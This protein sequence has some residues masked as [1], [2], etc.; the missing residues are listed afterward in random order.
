MSK[1][2]YYF[3]GIIML[4]GILLL[5][6]YANSGVIP[7]K[8]YMEGIDIGG[9]SIE[10]AEEL[11]KDNFKRINFSYQTFSCS[12][13]PEELGIKINWQQSFEN[14]DRSVWERVIMNFQE[15]HFHLDKEYDDRK[16]N[17]ALQVVSDSAGIPPKDAYLEMENGRLVQKE[18]EWGNKLDLE[19]LKAMIMNNTLK[20]KYILPMWAVPPQVNSNDLEKYKPAFLLGEY[21][22]E[23]VQNPNRTENIK[24]ACEAV[25]NTL[26]S[27]GE[28]F[29]FNKVVGPREEDKGYLNAMVILGGEFIPGLGGGICQVSSTL[30]NSVLLAGLEIVERYPHS[31][32]IDYVPLGRDATVNYGLK[33]FK[34]K[35]N[36]EGYLLI[37]YKITGQKLTF[38]IFGSQSWQD[39]VQVLEI[40]HY[41]EKVIGPPVKTIVSQNLSPQEVRVKSGGKAGY[42]VS[43][44]RIMN[45]AGEEIKEYLARDY[46]QPMPKIIEKGRDE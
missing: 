14:L 17:D 40:P 11:M 34:F 12:L 3:T 28:T 2:Y 8:V 26:L 44:Y 30:Y 5:S 29:S 45:V 10:E 24:I 39:K 43:T 18:G 35:N 1:K 25:K 9:R 7:S 33:D 16:I 4:F 36:T 15:R 31:L 6:G 21:T 23:F 13:S 46:Y 27:P 19:L 20:N 38:L 37:D 41:V 42:V 32:K 22:T